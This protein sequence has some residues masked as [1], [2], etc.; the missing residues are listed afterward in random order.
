VQE[1]QF[2]FVP[3]KILQA[4]KNRIANTRIAKTEIAGNSRQ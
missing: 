1:A 3:D 4:G 2:G